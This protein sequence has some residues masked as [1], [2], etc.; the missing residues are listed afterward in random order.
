MKS[1][2]KNELTEFIK[3]QIEK[4][5]NVPYVEIDVRKEFADYNLDSFQAVYIMDQL[6]KYLETELSPLYFFDNPTID[7]FCSFIFDNILNKQ[8]PAL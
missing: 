8:S 1:I 7:S 5:C 6:E 2:T 3:K 4:E